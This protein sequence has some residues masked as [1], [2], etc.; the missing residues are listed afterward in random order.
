[1]E[2]NEASP[3]KGTNPLDFVKLELENPKMAETACAEAWSW[4]TSEQGQT[5]KASR[6]CTDIKSI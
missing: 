4:L 5:N 2:T 6:H 3:A 1:M